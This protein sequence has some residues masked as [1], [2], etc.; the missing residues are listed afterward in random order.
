MKKIIIL[1]GKSEVGKTTILNKLIDWLNS[2]PNLTNI[3][4][5]E[6]HP[7]DRIAIIEINGFRIGILTQGDEYEPVKRHLN[8]IHQE[9][10][11]VIVCCCRTRISSYTAV[12]EFINK[13]NNLQKLYLPI[14]INLLPPS[15]NLQ[16]N[17][18]LLELKAYLTGIN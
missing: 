18:I 1:K 12:K 4:I 13:H 5:T 3:S 10:C 6:L 16:S 8:E 11:D 2:N 7:P 17:Q 15:N 14:W 9:N